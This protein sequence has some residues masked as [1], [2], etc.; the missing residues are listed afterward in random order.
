MTT[1][2]QQQPILNNVKNRFLPIPEAV[3]KGLEPEPKIQDFDIQKELGN[4]S[5]GRVYLVTHKKTKV[6][7]AIKAIDKQN[8]TNI[9]EKPYFRREIEI[10]YKIHHP[11]V[12]KLFGH[13]EDDHYCYFIMEYISKGNIYQLIPKDRHRRLSTQVVASLMKDVIS[14]V[15][16]LHHMNPP[17]IHR[18]IKPEN[19][20]LAEGLVAKL[21]DF[22]WSNY[23]EGAEKRMTVCGTPIYL[24]PEIINETGHDEKVDIW[25][26]GV[27]LFELCS[28]NVPFQ[29]NDLES[30]KQNIRHMKIMWP[31]DI[32]MDAKN[33]ISQILKYEASQRIGLVEILNHPFFTKFYPNAAQNLIKP[34]DNLVYVP[35]I[36]SKDN[37]K[38][39][40][41]IHINNNSSENINNLNNN[42]INVI[43]KNEKKICV[44]PKK[45][46][47]KNRYNR[48]I[49]PIPVSR[50]RLD[51]KINNNEDNND[52]N[53]N[54]FNTNISYDKYMI[55]KKKYEELKK[56]YENLNSNEKLAEIQKELTETKLKLREKEQKIV[57]LIKLNKSKSGE[58]DDNNL[59]E[60]NNKLKEENEKLKKLLEDKNNNNNNNLN[61]NNNNNDFNKENL[62]QLIEN[63][64][65]NLNDDQLKELNIILNEKDKEI[66]NIKESEKI[67]RE[68]EKEKYSKVV[69]KYD[70]TLSYSEKENKEL[71]IKIKELENK[72]K[73]I[74]NS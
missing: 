69:K 12:V 53:F 47:S 35:Y 16:F 8:K 33:L 57:N 48:D 13:F 15:Y 36:V 70:K 10:M 32:N 21:T 19:V 42:N 72:L 62:N 6:Q 1:Q 44:L 50:L 2:T 55:I 40:N 61:N 5:F 4:G 67:I 64:K 11:N 68:K 46:N 24:A 27:L 43:K 51:N 9:E 73:N 59:I 18:D 25:C 31:R 29:G 38:N 45:K 3:L 22:G 17:I 26:I 74:S 7:Y 20:L 66:E 34:D 49:S 41:P 30:L 63:F 58:I 14:A 65:I 23:M 52:N 60:E 39:Y 71:K 54:N 37:P 56:E 28:G